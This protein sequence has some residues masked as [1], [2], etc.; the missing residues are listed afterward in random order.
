MLLALEYLHVIRVVY[1]D[2]KTEN[3]LVREDGHIMLSD[4]DL[5][6]RLRGLV[7]AVEI[8]HE[9]RPQVPAPS[10]PASN[11]HASCP[12]SSARGAQRAAAPTRN[13]R[14]ASPGSGLVYPKITPNNP[15]E[16]QDS[17]SEMQ[18]HKQKGMNQE[19]RAWRK[20]E[21]GLQSSDLWFSR[22]RE[23]V[24]EEG[25]C[26]LRSSNLW[27]LGADWRPRRQLQGGD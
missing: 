15:Q 10:P 13:P 20:G 26:H 27:F 16:R 9:L 17:I 4:F 8:F 25:A 1:R 19:R 7:D 18:N 11:P 23:G 12:S 3:V 24:D 5:S 6:G 14:A 2:L 21:G 22:R